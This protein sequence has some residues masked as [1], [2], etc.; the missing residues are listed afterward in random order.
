[1]AIAIIKKKQA[2]R[3]F[4]IVSVCGL[5]FRAFGP[6]LGLRPRLRLAASIFGPSGLISVL[7]CSI[8]A[9]YKEVDDASPW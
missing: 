5:Y 6:Q 1:M 8:T 3:I 7:R 9:S 2:H 4:A